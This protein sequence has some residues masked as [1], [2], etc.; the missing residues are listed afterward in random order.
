MRTEPRS[1]PLRLKHLL[2]PAAPL[3]APFCDLPAGELD[4]KGNLAFRSFCA[5]VHPDTRHP[6]FV[7]QEIRQGNRH[8]RWTSC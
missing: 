5:W 4:P 6:R 7:T 3:G 2:R 1:F 8:M